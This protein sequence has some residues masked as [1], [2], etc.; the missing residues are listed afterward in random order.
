MPDEYVVDTDVVSYA[1]RGDSRA[2]TFRPYFEGAL[3][4]ISFM[5]LAEL[6]QWTLLRNWGARRRAQLDAFVARFTVIQPDRTLC[7]KWAEVCVQA[8]RN[9]R[10]IHV[11][12][13][14]IAATALNL[15]IPLL[16]H[17]GDDYAGVMSLVV[18]PDTSG[19]P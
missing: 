16:T 13:A 11:A 18:L 6:D 12:D 5:T 9:G 19:R 1:F 10:P 17:N 3:L 2:E 14:W 7:R 8:R 4:S 15:G